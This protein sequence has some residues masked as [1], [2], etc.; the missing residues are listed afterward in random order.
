MPAPIKPSV[1]I[2]L[3]QQLD[4]RVGRIVAVEDVPASRKLVRLRVSFG[5]HERPI[6]AGLKTERPDPQA[7]V[8]LQAGAPAPA[9]MT[10]TT[11]SWASPED[12]AAALN[13]SLLTALLRAGTEHT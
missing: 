5:D 11:R 10:I 13:T 4:I 8:G 6:L 3:F 9:A 12:N 7:L 1:S 2:D